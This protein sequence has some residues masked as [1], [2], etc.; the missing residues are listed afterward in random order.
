MKQAS[1]GLIVVILLSSIAQSQSQRVAY[2]NCRSKQSVQFVSARSSTVGDSLA[3]GE[4]VTII[5]EDDTKMWVK[6]R[7]R[8][9]GDGY[10]SAVYL[11]LTNP[12]AHNPPKTVPAPPM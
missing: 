3:G 7:T 8:D 4:Q 10:V 12:Y 6:V 9:K 2:V 1:V 11:S 5:G